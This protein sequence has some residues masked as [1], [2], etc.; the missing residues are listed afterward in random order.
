MSD[1]LPDFAEWAKV[2]AGY[3]FVETMVPRA[4]DKA[5]LM[6]YGWALR[7]AF[8]AGAVWQAALDAAKRP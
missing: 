3:A 6:W 7:E 1:E 2:E 4:D 5:N 8:V